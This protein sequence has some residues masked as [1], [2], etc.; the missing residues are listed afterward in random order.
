MKKCKL[1]IGVLSCVMLLFAVSL[2]V[3]QETDTVKNASG[4]ETAQMTE[5]ATSENAETAKAEAEDPN[6][7]LVLTID[8]AVSYALENNK[9]LKSSAIDLEIAKRGKTYSWNTFLPGLGANFTAARTSD[10]STYEN[11]ESGV[12]QGARLG[13]L[14]AGQPLPSAAYDSVVSNAGFEDTEKYHWAV[15]ADI[16][17]SWNFNLAMIQSIKAATAKYEQGQITYE[18]KVQEI[19]LNIRKLFYGLLVQK[20]SLQIEKEKLANAKARFD[21]AS[22]NYNA[23]IVPE[24]QKLNAQVTYE[25]QKPNVLSAEQALKQ[26]LDTLAFL[27]GMPYGKR[28]ELSGEIEVKFLDVD[29]NELYEKSID[30]N[31]EIQNLRKNIDLLNVSLNASRMSTFTPTFAFGY[32]FNPMIYAGGDVP[33]DLTDNGKLTFTLLYQN[34]IDMLPFSANMQKM[35]DTKQQISQVKL[36]LE[37]LMQNTEIQVHTLV[38]NLEKCKQNILSMER[39]VTL[40]QTAYNSTLRAYNN[41]TQELLE[42]RDAENSLNQSKLGLLNEKMNYKTAVLD[43]ENKLNVKLDK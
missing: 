8:D 39:N 34:I 4:D 19:E 24:L 11:I 29:A 33:D 13:A 27:I 38:D 22:A 21:Q 18:Q 14:E 37:Q 5:T 41:G 10:N 36:G 16:S 30:N 31:L 32:N 6:A 9:T 23:G 3:A 2:T 17:V 1:K 7:V 28:I 42:V 15:L 35:K 12:I 25:N 40:A 20:E 43:L 26:N